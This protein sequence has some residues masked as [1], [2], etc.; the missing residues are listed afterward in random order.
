[1]P[2]TY[3][4]NPTPTVGVSAYGQVPGQI[5]KP[6]SRYESVAS[7]YPQFTNQTSAAG[8]LINSQLA[9]EFTPETEAALW[10]TAN[11]YGVASGMPGAGLWSN[12]FMGN[13][14]GA[15]EALQQRGLTNYGQMASTLGGMVDDPALLASIA[16]SNAVLGAAPDPAAASALQLALSRLGI[17]TGMGVGGNPAGGTMVNPMAGAEAWAAQNQASQNA[18][19]LARQ[20]YYNQYWANQGNPAGGT[21]E[22]NLPYGSSMADQFYND[23]WDSSFGPDEA[24]LS[25]YD[26]A[27]LRG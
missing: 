26:W 21:G 10:D 1:M 24:Y 11:R 12:K 22:W 19:D 4:L 2:N 16:Q 17:N 25:Q 23:I 18:Q 9:G 13:V 8:N 20:N 27:G 15:K 7:I 5:E 6:P 14:V 3:N